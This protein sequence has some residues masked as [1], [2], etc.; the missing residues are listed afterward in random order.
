MCG[1]LFGFFVVPVL[2]L[3][4]GNLLGPVCDDIAADHR[5]KSPE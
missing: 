4:L 5:R 3:V 2:A 1:F